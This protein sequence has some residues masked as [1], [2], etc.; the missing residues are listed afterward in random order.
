MHS[1]KDGA[2]E[3]VAPEGQEDP[4]VSLLV[5]SCLVDFTCLRA[6]RCSMVCPGVTLATSGQALEL[7]D[8]IVDGGHR[9]IKYTRIGGVGTEIY[10]EGMRAFYQS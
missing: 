4:S 3:E 8:T 1:N 9:A 5:V 10:N 6:T 2:W 7:K